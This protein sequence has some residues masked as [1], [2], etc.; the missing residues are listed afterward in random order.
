MRTANENILVIVQI[1]SRLAIENCEKIA[2]VDGI[3]K[4]FLLECPVNDSG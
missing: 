4:L 2:A 1:E 3:G